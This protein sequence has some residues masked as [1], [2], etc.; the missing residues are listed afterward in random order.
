RSYGD[1][2]ENAEFKAAKE[3][4]AVLMRQ[5]AELEQDL[6]NARGTDFSSA[7]TSQVNVGTVVRVQDEA[8]KEE[9]FTILGAWDT[10]TEKGIISYLSQ[11]GES[12]IG[13]KPG[14]TVSLPAGEGD[15]SR[16]ATIVSVEAYSA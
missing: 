11:M 14:E 16:T 7:D 9:V 12:L 8:G 2:R 4:Q 6:A 10:D 15:S 3:M 1:L 13:H 5:Q